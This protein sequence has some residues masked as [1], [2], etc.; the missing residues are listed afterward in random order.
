MTAWLLA[1]WVYRAP[2]DASFTL[3]VLP[4]VLPRAGLYELETFS[5][6]P[7][8]YRWT[9]GS[10]QIKLPNPGGP[11]LVRLVLAGGPG[12]ITAARV[13]AGALTLAFD[14][15]PEPRS[16]AFALPAG[17]GEQITLALDTPTFRDD[18]RDL[19]VVLSDL[20]I[21]GGGAVPLRLL[22]A[23]ALATA[24]LYMLLRRAGWSAA[25]AGGTLLL[26]QVLVLLWQSQIGWRYGLLGTLLTLIGAAGLA[27][28]AIERW[29]PVRDLSVDPRA[30]LARRDAYVVAGLLALALCVRLPWLT[31][32]D[33][34]GD[35][36]LSAR[37]MAA[38]RA[39]GLAGAY[40][41]DGDYMPLRLYWLR[42][43]S[44]LPFLNHASFRA[45]LPPA[46]LLLIKLP[47]LLADLATVALLYLWSRRWRA[48]AGAA[49]LAALYALAPPV[50]MNVA[51]WGQVDAILVL[52]ILL[53][54]ALLD[55]ADGRWS[56]ACWVIAL[57][58]KPQAIIF[59]PVLYIV[60]L[61]RYGCPGLLAGGGLAAALAALGCAPL[62]LAGQGPGL[63]QAYTGAVGRFPQ[64]DQPRLQPVVPGHAGRGWGRCWAGAGAAK[65]SADRRDPDRRRGAAG[66]CGA[67]SPLGCGGA[68][69]GCGG[70]G[71]GVFHAADADP[72][73]LPVFGA[74]A[75]GD[76]RRPRPNRAGGVCDRDDFSHAQHSGR[77]AWLFRTG[78]RCDCRLAAAA[79]CGGAECSSVTGAAWAAA[80][81]E[82]GCAAHRRGS[83]GGRPAD[84]GVVNNSFFLPQRAQRRHLIAPSLS[85]LSSLW[86]IIV[87]YC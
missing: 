76:E 38:L 68:G 44:V 45:P 20:A 41:D 50:W 70:A 55:R 33:P 8:I 65:L 49:A 1:L 43:F 29:W 72:R 86:P 52:P 27:A 18:S 54:L 32:P 14:V 62:L 16:Y 53:M 57:M 10:A 3:D 75:A 42:G 12:R 87:R 5:D 26:L 83:A 7:G 19:G 66:M 78:L 21:S 51:W 81:A 84:G 34:V 59:A 67:N 13:G 6:R 71:A 79:G 4:A 11:V 56:W 73:T 17:A 22:P 85:S 25:W 82:P 46:T 37:R 63:L 24:G 40:Y 15:R 64:L 61:R 69:A 28:V 60:T 23:L 74:G 2:R 58:I 9:D 80:R 48:L 47:G 30:T 36:E 31:V 77:A 39:E 35:L